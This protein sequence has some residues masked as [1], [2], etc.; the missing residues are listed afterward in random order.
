MI[1]SAIP[2]AG[3]AAQ[4]VYG[5]L[6][7]DLFSAGGS[8]IVAGAFKDPHQE[9]ALYESRLRQ[10]RATPAYPGKS[11]VIGELE[12]KLSAARRAVQ[13]KEETEES[14]R[15]FSTGGKAITYLTAGLLVAATIFVLRRV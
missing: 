9:V 2:Y 10:A 14:Q 7:T 5:D 1:A 4:P 11:F 12:A 15:V 6:F 3:P 13:M 8:E